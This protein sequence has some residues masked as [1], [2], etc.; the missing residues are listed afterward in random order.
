MEPLRGTLTSC[1]QAS[2]WVGRGQVTST[3]HCPLTS[4]D[5]SCRATSSP[6]GEIF[7]EHRFT[8]G[9]KNCSSHLEWHYAEGFL[10]AGSE[11]VTPRAKSNCFGGEVGAGQLSSKWLEVGWTPSEEGKKCFSHVMLIDLRKER[12][13][14][15]WR[16]GSGGTTKP[17]PLVIIRSIYVVLTM[18]S[19]LS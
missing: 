12:V 9:W 16:M 15:E 14:P 8:A 11:K 6:R 5:G 17:R 4:W 1:R 18:C 7:L 3:S 10:S 19:A 2:V 13:S